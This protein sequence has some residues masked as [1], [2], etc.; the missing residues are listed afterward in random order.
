MKDFIAKLLFSSSRGSFWLYADKHPL[1]ILFRSPILERLHIN[2]YNAN[3]PPAY[4]AQHIASKLRQFVDQH[5]WTH[6]SHME[7]KQCQNDGSTKNELKEL[8]TNKSMYLLHRHLLREQ[9]WCIWAVVW[10]SGSRRRETAP[11]GSPRPP[12]GDAASQRRCSCT[13]RQ[14]RCRDRHTQLR[15]SGMPVKAW[16]SEVPAPTNTNGVVS[17]QCCFYFSLL[18][19]TIYLVTHC[20]CNFEEKKRI[21]NYM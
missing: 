1:F 15:S 4:T 5:P 7:I 17:L 18:S 16:L 8:D 11:Q 6:F 21:T 13:H 12:H 9:G 2:E 3:V 19:I 14:V 20:R 10:A